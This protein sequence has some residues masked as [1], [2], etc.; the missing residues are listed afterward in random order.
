MVSHPSISESIGTAMSNEEKIT[1]VRERIRKWH[2]ASYSHQKKTLGSR[3]EIISCGPRSGKIAEVLEIKNKDGEI[4]SYKLTIYSLKVTKNEV[5]EERKITLEHDQIEALYSFL[6]LLFK[7]ML[8]IYDQERADF[9][10]KNII[11]YLDR[12]T[13][14]L[15]PPD[16]LGSKFFNFTKAVK[17]SSFLNDLRTFLVSNEDLEVPSLDSI[18][19]LISLVGNQT[20]KSPEMLIQLLKNTHLSKSD[21]DIISGRKR[22]LEIFEEEMQARKWREPEW[23]KFFQENT[24]I[25]GYGLDYKF[26]GVLAR[27]A[28]VSDSDLD[29]RDS[30][31]VDFLTGCSNFT[32]LVELKLPET[33]LFSKNRN[34]SRS[35]TLSSDLIGA[36]SQILEQKASW[37]IKSQGENYISQKTYDPKAILIIGCTDE[38]LSTSSDRQ[39]QREMQ[40]KAKTFELFRRDS[41]NIEII[42]YD[43]LLERARF[44]V[45]DEKG[46]EE[47]K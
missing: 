12:I 22:G 10:D 18:R 36:T 35:W 23:Q 17:I 43:E 5:T 14:F 47:G 1:E 42:T 29:G 40:I 41:R 11:S 16:Q 7:D 26:L 25:F 33:P 38:F 30:V 13:Y 2:L 20:A 3:H 24:W 32:T 15:N 21:L 31:I 46:N 6:S 39:V 8:P 44:I 9:L 4:S 45:R 34:R 37:L 27:E 19:G 28:H